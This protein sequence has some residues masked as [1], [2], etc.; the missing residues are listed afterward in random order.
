MRR[1]FKNYVLLFAVMTP[2]VLAFFLFPQLS[3]AF[4]GPEAI[5]AEHTFRTWKNWICLGAVGMPGL[6]SLLIWGFALGMSA[7]MKREKT[8]LGLDGS[9][10]DVPRDEERGGGS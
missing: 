3:A 4:N 8:R 9:R 7:Y 2:A 1:S 5:E 6:L 10:M